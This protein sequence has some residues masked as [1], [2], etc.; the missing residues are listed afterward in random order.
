[1]TLL[2][3]KSVNE[4]YYVSTETCKNSKTFLKTDIRLVLK[5][6]KWMSKPPNIQNKLQY[7]G[8]EQIS[9][10]LLKFAAILHHFSDFQF[11]VQ[12]MF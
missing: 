8:H 5:S 7:N 6:E 11:V 1:M 9:W 12:S 2:Q 3:G 4:L 10:T